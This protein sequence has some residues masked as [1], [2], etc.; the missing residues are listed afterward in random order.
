MKKRIAIAVAAGAALLVTAGATTNLAQA[1][2][3]SPAC[4]VIHGPNGLHLQVGYAPTGPDACTQI[5]LG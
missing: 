1:Q 4:V 2:A 3:S 5:P